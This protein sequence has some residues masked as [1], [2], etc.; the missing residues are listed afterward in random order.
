VAIVTGIVAAI[1]P[2]LP[3]GTVAAAATAAAAQ[4]GQRHQLA[5]ALQD[6]PELLTGEGAAAPVPSVLR[7]IGLLAQAGA[8]G[9]VVPP[10]P[11]CGRVIP[12]VKPRGGVRLCRNCVARSRAEPCSRCGTVR[13][14]ATRDK[15]GRPLCPHC[16][17]TDPANQET[18]TGCGRRR[19]VS[20][21]TPDGPLC[22]SCRPWQTATCGICGRQA[23]CVIS[24]ATGEP[25]CV[26]CK[27]RRA[28]CSGCGR[29]GRVRGGTRAEPLCATCTRPGPGFWR[30][31]PACGETG[32][33]HAGRCARCAVDQRLRELL[34]DEAGEIRPR[35][36]ALYQA[37]SAAERPGTAAAWLDRSQA[38]SILQSL[39][40]GTGL[41]HAALDAL[42][43]GKPVEHLRSVLVAIGTLPHRDEQ[44]ARLERWTT[45]VI[46]GRDDPGQRQLLHSYAVWHLV[47]RLRR[48]TEG[49]DTTHDQ[50]VGVRQHIKAAIAFLDWLTARHLT[51]GTCRQ[52][53]LDAWITGDQARYRR[54]TGHFVRWAGKQKLTSLDFP[55]TRWS[56]PSR[57]IDTEARWEQ[58]RR[59][60]RDGSLDPEDRVAGLL[61]LLYAQ[62]PSVISRLT[63]GHVHA[64]GRQVRLNLGREPVIL[65]EPLADLVRQLLATRRGHA[66]IAGPETT[67]WLFPGGQPGRPVSS[68]RMAERLRELGIKAGQARSTALFQLATDLPAAVLARMLGIHIAVAV[69]WQRAS[70]GD[71]TAYAAEV[72]RRSAENERTSPMNAPVEIADYD[73]GWPAAFAALRDQTAAALGPLAQRIEHVGS[74]A[75]PGRPAKPVIDLDVV[76]ATH[77]DLP[78][79]ITRLAALG[80]RHEGDLGITGR[81]AFASPAAAPARHLYVCTADS[82]ELARHLAFR[83]YLR[84]HPEQARA[85]AELKRSLAAQ[86][87]SDRDAYSRSKAA[88]VEQALKAAAHPRIGT[89]STGG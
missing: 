33:I 85:Y 16:L 4:A 68:Y 22:P 60:Q 23:P 73:P 78:E 66:A 84:T 28:R 3:A 19:P 38:P 40:A 25:W 39:D 80:Y 75:G 14:A 29:T 26:A 76:I 87:R 79:V 53:D 35:L 49:T 81:E 42:P 57:V 63:L 51:L 10:C 52:N 6:R 1:D 15:D 30:S 77:A 82:P 83:D 24:Q 34:G 69:A 74:T 41:T 67:P 56:G 61:V 70:A 21:R 36:R 13:E 65:P 88:F 58:A 31:C 59:L 54:E 43:P 45:T 18:C 44:M 12:L 7:L 64:D 27:Q 71:W 17:I 46:A 11:H 55:A 8:K 47:R 62:W 50:L 48:R 9:I 2:E 5:W 89:D 86:F 20:V 72:S 32:R 37:L